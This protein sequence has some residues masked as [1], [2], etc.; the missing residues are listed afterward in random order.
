MN[1]MQVFQNSEFGS[2]GVLEINGKPHFPATACAKI[3]GYAKP[4]NAI[5]QHCRYSLKQGVPHPQNPG[6]NV[7]MNFISEGDLYRLIVHSKLP[8]AERFERWVF[9]EVLPSIRQTGGY[10]NMAEALKQVTDTFTA[11]MSSVLDRLDRLEAQSRETSIE[12]EPLIRRRP[13]SVISRLDVN[14]RQDVE[15]MICSGQF[16]YSE[17][18]KHLADCGIRISTTSVWRYAQSLHF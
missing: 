16:T 1:E 5:A 9:D 15:A 6:K 18:A 4:H 17:I 10:G 8:A 2:L 13:T 14:T 3:L 7:E 11:A 12:D